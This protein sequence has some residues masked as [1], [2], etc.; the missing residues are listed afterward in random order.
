MNKYN[1][2]VFFLVLISCNQNTNRPLVN[3]L[4]SISHNAKY[5]AMPVIERKS[6]ESLIGQAKLENKKLFLVF[7][8]RGCS[9]CK[10]FENYHND[11]IVNKIL[12]NHLI[13]KKIDINLTPGGKE[14]YQ[15]YGKAGFPSWTIIDSTKV[16][17]ADSDNLKNGSGNIGFPS[18]EAKIEYYINAIRKAAPSLNHSEC[19]ILIKKL[20][21]YGSNRVK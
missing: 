17:I 19:D 2:I 9:I 20:N 13:I 3:E 5:E 8:F 15:T 12:S 14:L 18:S 4:S 11:S 10:I 16:V 6:F 7:S 21:D 1:F